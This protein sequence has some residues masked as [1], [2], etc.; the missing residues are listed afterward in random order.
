[1]LI[2]P[3]PH[4]PRRTLTEIDALAD[5]IRQFSLLQPI[6]VR[7]T[8]DRYEILGGHRRF[9]AY[10]T[11]AKR[12]PH[13]PRWLA[14]P[15]VVSHEKDADTLLRMLI[16]GQIHINAWSPKE[17]AAALEQLMQHGYNAS[18]V[19]AA[20][21]KTKSWASKR[22]RV[23]N[24]SVL[25]GYV[26]TGSLKPGVAEEL[27]PV[28]DLDTKRKIAADAATH[29][30]SQDQVKG[31]VRALRMDRQLAQVGRLARELLDILS[32]LNPH[33]VP[34]EFSR[35][36]WT[37]HGRI[38]VLGRG[39]ERKVP[40]IDE[41]MKAAGIKSQEAP[42][43]RGRPRKTVQRPSLRASSEARGRPNS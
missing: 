35:D 9:A 6:T 18:Q 19:G 37:L 7:R 41:A 5:N 28:L 21:N 42:R 12:E 29:N 39:T 32:S 25:S 8:D 24:D 23:Y 10:Q 4:N 15:A 11:L 27:L 34:I 22:L 30:L 38:E 1:M 31:R 14:I 16:S 2:D 33:D 3:N 17:E 26:Q 20:L 36:L 40:T 43:R 13:E